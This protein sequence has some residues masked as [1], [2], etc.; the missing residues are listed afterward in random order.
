M[1]LSG[2]LSL[3]CF[4]FITNQL[5]ALPTE[6]LASNILDA[7]EVSLNL[8]DGKNKI[9]IFLSAKCPCSESHESV[10]SQ[11]AAEFKNMT[12]VGIHSNANESVLEAKAHFSKAKLPFLVI[13]DKDAKIADAFAALKTP[14]AFIV[15]G[16]GEILYSG[17]VT[18][19]AHAPMATQQFLKEALLSVS[20]GEKPQPRE[21]RTL[22]CVIA[23]P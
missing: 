14:H 1:K 4:F 11:L 6:L 16:G 19:S 17:G 20:K 13:Q 9:F 5:K 15:N 8:A 22:G 18:N 3:I 12:F 21:L 10:L 23:R 2:L 7:K